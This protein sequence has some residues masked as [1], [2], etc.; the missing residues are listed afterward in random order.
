MEDSTDYFLKVIIAISSDTLKYD[1][2]HFMFNISDLPDLKKRMVTV[3]I[4]ISW[5]KCIIE[6]VYMT[7]LEA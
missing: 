1:F 6:E 5:G 4:A 7:V 3:I 2:F